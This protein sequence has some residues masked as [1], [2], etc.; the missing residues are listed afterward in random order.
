MT[1]REIRGLTMAAMF[2]I[3]KRKAGWF[4]PSQSGSGHGYIV[5]PVE[6]SPSCTCAD[7]ETRGC[8]C[9]HIF[10]VRFVMQREQNADGTETVTET[11]TVS[12]TTV[13]KTYGQNWPAYNRAQTS[14]KQRFQE[15]L[16]GL[17]AGV[18]ETPRRTTGR[19]RLPMFSGRRFI[20]DLRDA[21]EKGFISRVPHF[22]SIFNYLENEAVT[23]I[24]I[25]LITQSSL[26]LKAVEEN[27]AVDSSGFTSSRFVRWYDQ[28]Y[29]TLKQQHRWMKAQVMTGVKTNIVTAVEILD[30]D[31]SD[32][33]Y[34]PALVRDTAKNFRIAEVSADKGYSSVSNHEVVAEC[35]G[36]PFIAFK[37]VATGASGGLWGQMFHYF[38]FRRDE[39]LTHYHRRSNVE[40]TFSMIKAKFRDSVRSKTDTA[41]RNEIL[42][43]ILCHN[44]CV[45]IQEIFELGI[46]PTFWAKSTP[47]QQL[48]VQGG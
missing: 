33:P 21:H 25:Q 30:Q 14:E 39:F 5:D 41:M 20:S 32:S 42:C 48:T 23:P 7:H 27:F 17:C 43:K 4:V 44:I 24:L 35:G 28:K 22:N 3:S 13:R 12:E 8:V 18:E 10:A 31:G 38:S 29:G 11:I 26:P 19:P 37:K 46:E 1:D 45:L 34:L 6:E 2:K 36:T 16:N 15:L 40:S 47:A 9:K